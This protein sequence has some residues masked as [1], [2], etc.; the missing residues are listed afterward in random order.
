MQRQAAL[1]RLRG[2][3]TKS[4]HFT[5]LQ[6]YRPAV[7]PGRQRERLVYAGIASLV[8]GAWW[9]V[10]S[11]GL[12]AASD[13]GYWLGVAGGVSMLLLFA[14]PLRK[15]V[16]VMQRWGAAKWWFA[17]HMV[18]GIAGPVLILVHSTFQIGSLNAGVALYSMLIVA[19]SGVV[20]RFLYL[21][22][23]RGLSGELEGLASLQRD[24]GLQHDSL[25]QS[26][27]FA[28]AV[29]RALI[30][31]EQAALRTPGP[32]QRHLQPFVWMPWQRWQ[33]RRACLRALKQ[34]LRERARV[35]DWGPNR[36]RAEYQPL[37]ERVQAYL[38]AVQRVAQYDSATRLFS[39][40]HV[41]HVPFVYLMVLCAIAHV[42]AVHA[43]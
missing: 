31:F 19:G 16:K 6:P 41:L 5:P 30:D 13:L 22:T 17:V 34:A 24:L 26:L 36:L 42:I 9:L 11:T 15:R 23:H 39:L 12:K 3:S 29:E 7:V 28:P 37:R 25:H 20:G 27:A 40:W 33:V 2:M 1:D 43:Y 21:R 8:L 10:R 4:S 18:L 32:W 14:Y 38:A 35:K